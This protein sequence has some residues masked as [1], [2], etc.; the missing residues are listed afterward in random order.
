MKHQK[1]EIYNCLQLF[2]TKSR[3]K[4]HGPSNAKEYSNSYLKRKNTK[5][6]KQK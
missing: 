3:E 5:T 1:K 4:I 6:V 2:V